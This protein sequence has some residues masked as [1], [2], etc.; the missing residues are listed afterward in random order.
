M[1]RLIALALLALG[2]TA[3]VENTTPSQRSRPLRGDNLSRGEIVLITVDGCLWCDRQK[4]VLYGMDL[5]EWQYSVVNHST[6]P[7][8]KRHYPASIY[9]TLY[10]TKFGGET[11]TLTGFQRERQLELHLKK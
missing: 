10:I 11:K 1:I 5:A 2:L 6:H 3:C 4:E 9:P 7:D 8:L